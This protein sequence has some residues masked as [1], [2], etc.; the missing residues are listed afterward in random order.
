MLG[1]WHL[2]LAG[3][4]MLQTV[5]PTSIENLYNRDFQLWL[6]ATVESLRSGDFE[7]LD[8]V[9][10]IEEI[11]AL[12]KRDQR[13]LQSRLIVLLAHLLKRCYVNS[14]DD[15]RGWEVTIREQ[16]DE[17][18]LLLADS[19]S[20]QNTWESCFQACWEKALQQ[21]KTGYAGVEFPIDFPFSSEINIALSQRFW[22]S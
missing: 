11:E 20:L 15:F 22:E 21:V 10:L 7:Q 1:V 16:R 14:P 2:I 5:T 3:K 9:H 17:L 19:P 4:L 8:R 12:G 13:E 18:E 6:A